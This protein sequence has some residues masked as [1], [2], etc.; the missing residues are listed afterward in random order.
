MTS[1]DAAVKLI[2]RLEG[3]YANDPHD[4]GGETNFGIS[5]R[6]YP[7]LDIKA[8]TEQNAV[9]I[10][11]SDFWDAYACDRLPAPVALAF[12]DACI[13]QGPHAATVDLQTAA[14]TM[15]D[16]IIGT[17]TARAVAA[18]DPQRLLVAFLVA[19]ALRYKD[20]LHIARYADNWAHRLVTVTIAAARL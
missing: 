5:K 8:L 9:A 15:R 1:F 3:G 2:L 13:N 18:A 12:F 10:Y 7:T 20:N 6:S 16:G 14:G 4:P 17:A 19:R 11:K